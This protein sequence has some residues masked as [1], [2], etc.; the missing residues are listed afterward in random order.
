MK[1]LKRLL[2]VHWHHYDKEIIDFENINFLTGKTATGK[3][4]I[5]DALQLVLLGDTSGTFFNKA[6]NDKS[7]RTLKSYLFCEE[8][9]DGG[10]GFRYLRQG[11]FTS[12]VVV[13]FEDTEKQSNF[14]AG[15]VCDCFSDGTYKN[16][17]FVLNNSGI[18]ENNFIDGKTNAPFDI[19]ALNTYL[20][21]HLG[22]KG[23]NFDFF[24]TN[25]RYQEVILGKFGQMKQKYH[26]LLRKAVPFT[27]ITDIE[28]FITE[29]ICDVRN[30]I[31]VEKMQSDI[32]HYKNL[33][34]DAER[35]RERIAILKE[36]D[37]FNKSYVRE[38]EL[39]LT[40]SYVIDRANLEELKDEAAKLEEKLQ[41]KELEL[42]DCEQYISD[43]NAKLQK[44]TEQRGE[45]EAEY[46]NSDILA[47]QKQLEKD[48]NEIKD[49]INVIIDNVIKA[50]INLQNY[51]RQWA[52][53]LAYPELQCLEGAN[54]TLAYMQSLEHLN[55]KSIVNLDFEEATQKFG[56]IKE[57]V[58]VYAKEL[59]K[60]IGQ[61]KENIIEL[62]QRIANLR[63]GIKPYPERIQ[64]MK[65]LLEKEIFKK[66]NKAVNI[67]PLADLLELKDLKWQNAIEG[68]L[69]TQKFYLLVPREYYSFALKV[70]NAA[71]K[72]LG[73]YD[74][75]LIDIAALNKYFHGDRSKNSLAEEIESENADALLYASY[76]L[77]KVIK[78]SNVEELNRYKIGITA[79][80][81]LY[82]NF[83]SR[84]INPKLYESPFIGRKAMEMQLELCINE[85]KQ[86]KQE[87]QTQESAY[88]IVNKTSKLPALVAYEANSYAQNV[89]ATKLIP[90]LEQHQKLLEQE[91]NSLD[92][93]YLEKL[94]EEIDLL[95]V[96]SFK[97]NSSKE[98]F[99]EKRGSL[100]EWI[101][102]LQDNRLPQ[103]LGSIVALEQSIEN[104][105]EGVWITS[106]GEPKYKDALKETRVTQSLKASFERA[107]K[108]TTSR[109]DS[110]LANRTEQRS[111]YNTI[112]HMPFDVAKESNV[113]FDNELTGLND[114]KLPEYLDKIKDAKERAYVQFKDDFIAKIKSNIETVKQQID[115]L[116]SSLKQSVFGTDKYHFVIKPRAEYQQYYD[117]ITD[118][119]L[120]DTGGWNLTSENFNSKYQKEIGELFNMLILNETNVSAE[121]RAEYEKAIRKYTDYKTY[122][123]F[124]LIVTNEQGYEQRLSKTLLKKSGGETQ[125]PFYI[126]LLA[127]FSQVCRIRNKTQNNTIR[128]IILDEAFSKMDGERIKESIPL[129]R[130]FGLQAI[131]SAPPDKI[132]DIAP[133]VDRNIAVYKIGD[134]SFTRSFDPK[135][136]ENLE[137][138]A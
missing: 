123:V 40:Q 4:T 54:K 38:K 107:L 8:G 95:T 65:R 57:Q 19:T 99:I 33:E 102:N 137:E 119:M 34:E 109:R 89:E 131:F 24:D 67:A 135:D 45:K 60:R 81:M 31:D 7:A 97:L 124:D 112:Y 70:Y 110:Y 44:V 79:S 76:L 122:L 42:A 1:K 84:R 25:K 88:Q 117:M 62:E 48:I 63:K 75:G 22:K 86:Q 103:N 64:T 121:K 58:Q 13:E 55:T 21:N 90:K 133:L 130:K 37:G 56:Y 116:N 115:E 136:L 80:C 11:Q 47:K 39:Y 66:Y 68:Y 129:L 41:E 17:W 36:I 71:K 51:G 91:L 101:R 20:R 94:R 30:N 83:V 98:E 28:Q 35:I 3:S 72:E 53:D 111:K 96:Q 125:I 50:V 69:S 46:R 128:L 32:R 74:I 73:L 85:L 106:V 93:M 9:D 105:Y 118:P 120:M 23:S 127:S 10:A 26:T 61:I 5:I 6:A 100:R 14:S 29:S 87:A 16:R 113:D 126:A 27:P 108:A 114:V 52:E 132:P 134:Y 138:P 49:K 43:V 18:P 77:G 78:C 15:L 82:K 59:E 12:Y 92:L 2:L 104:N